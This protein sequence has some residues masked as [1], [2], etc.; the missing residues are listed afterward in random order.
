MDNEGN[1]ITLQHVM[2]EGAWEA[3]A[4]QAVGLPRELLTKVAQVA[5]KAFTTMRPSGPLQSYLDVFQG[6]Q[7]HYLQFVERLTAAIEQQEEDEVARRRLVTSLAFKH[8][9]QV[10][11]QAMLTLPRNTKLT[12]QDYIEVV[13]EVVPLMTPGR[14]EKKDHHWTVVAAAAATEAPTHPTDNAPVVAR[15]PR[16]ARQPSRGSADRPCALCGKRGH[17]W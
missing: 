9:N 6:P 10:C 4:K 17:W 15:T 12:L 11:K 3:P 8:A 13:T 16:P 1:L 7:E 5:M 2:G 14:L